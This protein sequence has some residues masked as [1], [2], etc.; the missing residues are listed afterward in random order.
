MFLKNK[1]TL[2]VGIAQVAPI[3]LDRDATLERV[4]QR[5][6]EAARAGSRL[7]A[8]GEGLVPGYPFWPERTGGAVF[9]S[10]VQKEIHARYLDQAVQLEA[11][12]LDRRVELR[13]VQL[14]AV[15]DR[16]AVDLGGIS[17]IE[18]ITNDELIDRLAAVELRG[19]EPKPED[20]EDDHGDDRLDPRC[21]CGGLLRPFRLASFPLRGRS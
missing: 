11:G 9:D 4:C 15:D 1:S 8:F 2:K 5:I 19:D 21:C 14:V 6:E 13:T 17:G 18:T 10:P 12:H 7:V 16:H 3:W 20:G